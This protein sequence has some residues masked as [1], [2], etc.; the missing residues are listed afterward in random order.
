MIKALVGVIQSYKGRP[1]TLMEVCGTHT[2]SIAKIGLKHILPDNIR[3]VSGPGCPVCVTHQNYIE[4]AL[5]L[6]QSAK[7]CTFGDLMRVPAAQGTLAAANDVEMVYAPMDAVQVA[8]ANPE[9]EVVFLSIGFETTTPAVALAVL[10]ARELGLQNL[11]FLTANKTMPAVMEALLSAPDLQVDGL[12]YP[13]HVAAIAGTEFFDALSR[14]HK[15][16]GVVAGFDAAQVLVGICTLLEMIQ[17]PT[18][19]AANIYKAVVKAE[20]NPKAQEIVRQ[21][22]EPVD[23]YW[24]GFGMIAQSGLGLR[25]KFAQFDAAKKFAP[26]L[27]GMK[28]FEEPIGCLCG[29]VLK[30]KVAPRDCGLF[31]VA[32]TPQN[33]VG[34]CMVSSEGSCAAEY[35]YGGVL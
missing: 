6:A 34:A 22:F 16:P 26:I 9:K 25:T 21:V 29:E 5:L 18:W 19:G 20:G 10:R 4:S 3:I 1:V 33:P 28:Q 2:M 23:A 30:G 17:A 31:G 7:I 32:C 24:R 27:Q 13:G 14:K 11:T 35:R 8:L 15:I 12:I